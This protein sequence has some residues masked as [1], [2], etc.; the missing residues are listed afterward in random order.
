MDV[1]ELAVDC[2][3]LHGEGAVWDGA[4]ARLLWTDIEGLALWWHEPDSGR[5]GSMAMPERL[6]CFA[7]RKT[8]GLLAGFESGFAVLDLATMKAEWIAQFEAGNPETRLNDGRT[9]RF[10]NFVAG[11]MNEVSNG[12]DSS[13]VRLS[14]GGRLETLSD[15]VSCANSICFSPDGK[16]MYFADS[17]RRQI[18]AYSYDRQTAPLSAPTVLAD[19]RQ[20]K[21]V[22]DGSCVDEEG[23]VW[24]AEWEGGRVVRVTPDGVIDRVIRVPVGKPTCCAFG[25][26]KLDTLFITTSRLGETSQSVLDNPL[27]GSLFAARPDVRGLLD[28]PYLG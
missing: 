26:E 5:S 12:F 25:G 27:Q 20:E 2:R 16:T 22:P 8:G 15:G 11:G 23:G 28:M 1:A 10:G 7:P 3:N 4:T 19:L 24:N 14:A 6:C 9:D 13:V 21:G 18:L 17:P